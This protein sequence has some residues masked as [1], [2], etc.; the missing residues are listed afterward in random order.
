MLMDPS[1]LKNVWWKYGVLAAYMM[2]EGTTWGIALKEFNAHRDRTGLF[3]AIGQSRDPTVF[4]VLFEDSAPLIGLVIDLVGPIA[5]DVFDVTWSNGAASLLI[6]LVLAVTAAMLAQESK[7]LLTSEAASPRIVAAMRDLILA[8]PAVSGINELKTIHLGPS[9]TLV[10]VSL[11]F[12][13]EQ[14]L[15]AVEDTVRV[16]GRQIKRAY[17]AIRQ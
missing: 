15:S 16:M 17:P 4:T 13:D 1:P 12:R 6:S 14:T 5:A 11:N 2:F 3:A 10:T 9:D 7:S 8:H